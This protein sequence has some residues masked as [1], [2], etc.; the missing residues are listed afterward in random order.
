M[1]T[2]KLLPL[3]LAA[4]MLIGLLPVSA[5]A[6]DSGIYVLMNIPYAEFYAAELGAGDAA[7]DAVTSSTLNKPRTGTLA[8]GSY[9]K[10]APTAPTSAA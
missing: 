10:K 7:V 8:G 5:S 2:H 3:L 1:R 6:A 9:H 4:L